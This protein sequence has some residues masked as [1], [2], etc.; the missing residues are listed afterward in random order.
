MYMQCMIYFFFNLLIFFF[1]FIRI[2]PWLLWLLWLVQIVLLFPSESYSF[3]TIPSCFVHRATNHP[4]SW[5]RIQEQG[6]NSSL[7]LIALSISFAVFKL[8]LNIAFIK[9][10]NNCFINLFCSPGMQQL[11]LKPSPLYGA[12][13]GA[14]NLSRSIGGNRVSFHSADLHHIVIDIVFA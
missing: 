2:R 13:V 12:L 5:A 9:R 7:I 11:R 6:K 8:A 4:N 1:N 3:W 10:G 14:S